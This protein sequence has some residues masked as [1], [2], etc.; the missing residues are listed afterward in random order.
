[1]KAQ[2]LAPAHSSKSLTF[3]GRLLVPGTGQSALL[4]G[5][6]HLHPCSN[7]LRALLSSFLIEGKWG[8]GSIATK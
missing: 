6:Y 2:L 7:T 4:N 1:M 8:S 5:L 3:I